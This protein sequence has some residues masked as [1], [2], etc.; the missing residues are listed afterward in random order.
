[1]WRNDREGKHPNACASACACVSNL[2]VGFRCSLK[3][4]FN[5]NR[6]DFRIRNN[7]NKNDAFNWT[8][9]QASPQG[10]HMY[11]HGHGQ[12]PH[13]NLQRYTPHWAGHPSPGAQA[14][15]DPKAH[16]GREASS[17]MLASGLKLLA[18]PPVTV[19]ALGQDL[20]ATFSMWILL[21]PVSSTVFSS[22]T[23]FSLRL[24]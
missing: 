19:C 4:L 12:L 23:Y 7:N 11:R 17:G 15:R 13:R 18:Q 10:D 21:S 22:K 1:M 14:P 2:S 6:C 16:S 20:G 3:F 8:K 5:M 9:I 24:Y